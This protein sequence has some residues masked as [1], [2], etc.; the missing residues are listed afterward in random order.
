VYGTA[1]A[2]FDSGDPHLGRTEQT[3]LDVRDEPYP[4]YAVTVTDV[5]GNTS[6]AAVVKVNAASAYPLALTAYP[7]PFNPNTTIRFDVPSSG[8]VTVSVFRS[9]GEFVATLFQGE[10]GP[11]SYEFPWNGE[12]ETGEAVSSGVYFARLEHSS[13][14]KTLKLV[15]VR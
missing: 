1:D 11:G 10:R 5:A 14:T 9:S 6:T 15:L 13:G 12:A 8:T 3:S 4:Y 7:N 2:T